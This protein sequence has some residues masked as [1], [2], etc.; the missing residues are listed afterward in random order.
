M[1]YTLILYLSMVVI[2]YI[3]GFICR[4]KGVTIPLTSNIQTILV[5][6]IILV[7]GS[8]I[9]SKQEVIDNFKTIGLAALL[10]TIFAQGVPLIVLSIG[11]R[12]IG[13]DRY[14]IRHK[15]GEKFDD[16]NVTSSEKTVHRGINK[17]TIYIFIAA[18]LG[19]IVGYFIILNFTLQNKLFNGD[20]SIFDEYA[21]LAIMILLSILLLLVGN[22]LGHD[23]NTI[24]NIR[25]A[26]FFIVLFPIFTVIG[27][28]IASIITGLIL[29][30]NIIESLAIGS[31][32]GWYSL[33][34]GIL[35]SYGLINASAI[36]F[37]HNIMREIIGIFFIPI[38]ANKLGYVE[39]TSLAGAA[40]MDVCLPIV[41]SATSPICAIYSFVSGVVLTIFVP[42]LVPLFASM[43]VM[44]G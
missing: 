30:I 6:V 1:D 27:V 5:F 8:R 2:G 35:M 26:G 14:G 13:F 12:L 39:T 18:V 25:K 34:P 33:A 31:G 38:V 37:L 4:K 16:K 10:F 36:S 20:I 40:G 24:G 29:K 22:D 28:M 21:N 17:M 9:G 43:V 7:M 32:M 41:E 23:E 11:R 44:G 42:I 15:I 3:V 19:I